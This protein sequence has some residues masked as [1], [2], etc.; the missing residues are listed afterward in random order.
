MIHTIYEKYVNGDPMTDEE[1]LAGEKHFK[2]LSDL[3]Y[4]SGE[5]FVITAK[6]ANRTHMGLQGY[7][8]SCGLKEPK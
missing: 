3:L 1:V 5:A 4:R 7:R 8:T 2:L 6:E